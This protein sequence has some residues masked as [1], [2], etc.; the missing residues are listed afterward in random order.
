MQIKLNKL[1]LENFKG[2]QSFTL[3]A[4]GRNCMI[5][6]VNAAGKTTLMDAFL[7]LLFGK[8]SQGKTDFAIKTLDKHGQELHN[9]NHSVEAELDIEGQLIT[10]KKVLA[11][12]Y[13]KK[14]GSARSEFTGHETQHF[15]D[16]VP[17]QKKEWD[18][19]LKDLI[20]EDTFKLL[21]S[22]TYFNALHW[23]ARRALLLQICG[24]ISDADV[25]NSD[26]A[27]GALPE[28]LEARSLEDHRKIIAGKKK[29]INDRLKEIPARIDELNKSLALIFEYDPEAIGL[30]VSA[31]NAQ[32]QAAKDDANLSALRKQKAEWEAKVSEARTAWRKSQA[33]DERKMDEELLL[34]TRERSSD[35]SALM[36]VNGQI[37]ANTKRATHNNVEMVRLREEF[38]EISGREFSADLTCPACGQDLPADQI[39]AATTKH[40][41][42]KAKRLSGINEQGKQFR[43]ENEAHASAMKLHQA[44]KATLEKDIKGLSGRIEAAQIWKA[45]YIKAADAGEKKE[46]DGLQLKVAE[47]Q[48]KIMANAPIDTALLEAQ[49]KIEQANLAEIEAAKKTEARIVTLS[50]EEKTLAAEYERLESETFLMEKFIV[51]KVE[52]LEG[53][54][55]S[56]F[57]LARFKL[58]DQQINEGIKETC[59]T[60]YDGVP[61]GSGLNTGAEINVGLDIVRT[62]SQH[63]G[64]QAPIWIDHA[65]SVIEILDPGSQTIK[66]AVAE[67]CP[68]LEV[69]YE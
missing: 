4:D 19:R 13:T 17:V 48:A 46:I 60:L 27:L 49:V 1:T 32:I 34:L 12:K 64:M 40:N 23:T 33:E 6:G 38:K 10:L 36:E 56:K 29:A 3:E 67:N 69:S 44:R 55:N 25:I 47:I 68:T 5:Q 24:D 41:E 28:I 18:S 50:E 8:D 31:L 7:W 16:G 59:V 26:H 37:D 45:D 61:Y 30:R 14:K 2:I 53:K 21:T 57:A 65:E 20:E 58:F 39:Q 63:Y 22:P 42:A 11:E 9:L 66:L 52:L 51:A 35:T 15:I 43:A 62:L 54:I